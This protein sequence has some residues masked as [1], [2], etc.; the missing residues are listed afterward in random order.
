MMINITAA[1]GSGTTH[2]TVYDFAAEHVYV[3]SSS[4]ASRGPVVPAAL[5]SYVRLEARALFNE[6]RPS[7]EHE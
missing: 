5:R 2:A 7:N 1:H 6:P 4:S 3:A